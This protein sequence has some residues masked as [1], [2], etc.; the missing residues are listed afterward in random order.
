MKLITGKL[1]VKNKTFPHL[2]KIGLDFVN[3]YIFNIMPPNENSY[4]ISTKKLPFN[5]TIMY[6][7]NIII[8]DDLYHKFLLEKD[9]IY[10]G[11]VNLLSLY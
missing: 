8:N 3:Y 2:Q 9:L 4:V 11:N 1:Y 7:G 5:T 10:I 6:I